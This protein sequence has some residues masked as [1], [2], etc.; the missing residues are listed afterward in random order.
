[1]RTR[2]GGETYVGRDQV[3]L[4]NSKNHR[5]RLLSQRQDPTRGPRITASNRRK[6]RAEYVAWCL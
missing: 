6:E 2:E 1:M 3:Q 4:H 5:W